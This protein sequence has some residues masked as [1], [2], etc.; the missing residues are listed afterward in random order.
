MHLSHSTKLTAPKTSISK[1]CLDSTAL[2]GV[3]IRAP[4][5]DVEKN[6][7][8]QFLGNSEEYINT[9]SSLGSTSEVTETTIDILQSFVCHMYGKKDS[10]AQGISI[11][12]LRYYVYC[13][14]AGKISCQTLTPCSNVIE[15]HI[16]KVNYQTRIW[17][18]CLETIVEPGSPTGKGWNIDDGR[19]SITWMTCNP[20]PEEVG[21]LFN[22]DIEL[23][24]I[25]FSS[26]TLHYLSDIFQK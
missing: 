15:Q 18:M 5:Q 1:P 4:F 3:I 2:P 9:F 22:R 8:L 11:N 21:T 6:K 23:K 13:Q 17:R 14:K 24:S 26:K 12:D 20:A 10:V 7:P 19:L 25:T 16:K